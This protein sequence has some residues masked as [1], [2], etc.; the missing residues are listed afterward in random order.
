MNSVNIYQH[1]PGP[2]FYGRHTGNYFKFYDRVTYTG[3][4]R[5]KNGA[6]DFWLRDL[7]KG[8]RRSLHRLG[9]GG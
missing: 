4:D 7:W 9:L 8:S 5:N 6:T 3:L 1:T 2:E